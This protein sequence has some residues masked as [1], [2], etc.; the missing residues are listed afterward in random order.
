MI[1]NRVKWGSMLAQITSRKKP[2][3]L[4]SSPSRVRQVPVVQVQR[5]V[6]VTVTRYIPAQRNANGISKR[7]AMSWISALILLLGTLLRFIWLLR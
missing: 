6:K 3:Q 1:I 7:V 4:I 2:V 5:H